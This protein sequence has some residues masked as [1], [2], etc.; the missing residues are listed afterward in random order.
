MFSIS[1]SWSMDGALIINGL[2]GNNCIGC[3][4]INFYSSCLLS[5]KKALWDRTITVI[6]QNATCCICVEAGDFNYIRRISERAGRCI[7]QACGVLNMQV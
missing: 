3:C 4:V 7:I 2:W 5:E 1:S 6:N